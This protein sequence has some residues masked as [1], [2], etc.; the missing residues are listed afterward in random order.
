MKLKLPPANRI[1][2][3]AGP[4]ISLLSGA[5]ASWLVVHVQVLGSLGL[6][7]DKLAHGIAYGVTAGV[8]AAI[9]HLSL[10]KWLDGHQKFS[11][12]LFAFVETLMD[13]NPEFGSELVK[14]L[15]AVNGDVLAALGKLFEPGAPASI[16][17]AQ[18]TDGDASGDLEH[19]NTL[20]NVL[21]PPLDDVPPASAFGDDRVHAPAAGDETGGA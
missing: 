17:T 21:E 11:S 7:Q 10:Q 14:A 1:V 20:V 15:P 9:P 8:G 13:G 18:P 4:Y 19:E 3:F 12:D 6:G 16:K 5:A 2:A